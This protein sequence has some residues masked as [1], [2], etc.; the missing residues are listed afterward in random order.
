MYTL[1]HGTGLTS[2][3][4]VRERQS[5]LHVGCSPGTM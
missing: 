4:S 3:V 1:H 5:V 2:N